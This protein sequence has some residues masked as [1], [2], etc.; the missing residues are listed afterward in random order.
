MPERPDKGTVPGM[1]MA[2]EIAELRAENAALRAENAAL[3]QENAELRALVVSLL[4]QGMPARVVADCWATA[5][6]ASR[7][8]PTAR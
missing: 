4:E 1:S 6:S 8:A 7:W 2:K 3:R 5:R